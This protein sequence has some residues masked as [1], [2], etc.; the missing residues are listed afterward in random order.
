MYVGHFSTI[1]KA[2]FVFYSSPL[3]TC[4]H[5]S[6]LFKVNQLWVLR[7]CN[8]CTTVA[9]LRTIQKSTP[10]V[11]MTLKFKGLI[12]MKCAPFY[13]SMRLNPEK[14]SQHNFYFHINFEEKTYVFLLP[15]LMVI[16]VCCAWGV[17]LL[18]VKL[19]YSSFLCC[20]RG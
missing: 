10:I 4:I 18:R 8:S 11:F 19:H 16:I 3:S 5:L 2:M 9:F 17:F 20:C 13:R 12:P 7:D 15:V 1:V 14:A 6:H